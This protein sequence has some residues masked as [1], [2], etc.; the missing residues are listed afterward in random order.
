VR[1]L[2]KKSQELQQSSLKQQKE[3]LVQDSLIKILSDTRTI[4]LAVQ[5]AD[6]EISRESLKEMQKIDIMML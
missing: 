6:K 5:E 1:K 2:L 4:E 3:K